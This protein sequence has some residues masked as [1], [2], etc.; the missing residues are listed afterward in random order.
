MRTLVYS[1]LLAFAAISVIA[2][3]QPVQN[4]IPDAARPLPLSAVRLNG[5]P[6]KHA[7]VS[8]NAH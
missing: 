7:H 8:V 4:A 3:V 5:G 1:A 2:A 6:L